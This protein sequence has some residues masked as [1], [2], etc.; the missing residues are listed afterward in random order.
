MWT[1]AL[2]NVGTHVPMVQI[3]ACVGTHT[4]VLLLAA[5]R[6]RRSGPQV[7]AGTAGTQ[8]VVSNTILKGTGTGLLGDVV[9]SRTDVGNTSYTSHR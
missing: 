6:P 2:L 7:I 9:G 8:T 3:C 4:C 1:P 5:E